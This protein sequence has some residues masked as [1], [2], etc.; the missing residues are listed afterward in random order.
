VTEYGFCIHDVTMSPCQRFRDCL[1]CTGQICIKGDGRIDRLK[2]RYAIVKLLRDK[3]AQ[4]I[5]DGTA[6]ADRWYHIHKDRARNNFL[7]LRKAGY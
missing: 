1:N 4:E 5:D 7:F 2:E 3:A 6:G